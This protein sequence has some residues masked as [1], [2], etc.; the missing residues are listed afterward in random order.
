MPMAQD[1]ATGGKQLLL[2]PYGDLWRRERKVMH[3]I[4]NNTQSRMFEPYQDVESKALLLEYARRPE[5]WWKANSSYAASIIMGVTLGRRAKPDDENVKAALGVAEELIQFF[6][7]G[8]AVVD[9]LP[10]LAKIPYFKSLQPWRWYGDDLYR[11]TTEYALL[12]YQ[13]AHELCLH[14]SGSSERRS[15][16]FDS[17]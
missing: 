8:R 5:D 10:F 14:C 9:L 15:T 4:L 3:Q 11:R 2:M 7:P 12:S 17:Q 13:I 16:R 1:L 6:T